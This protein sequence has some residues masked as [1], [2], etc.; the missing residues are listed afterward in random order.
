LLQN[1]KILENFWNFL[2]QPPPLNALQG[3][4]FAKVLTNLIGKRMRDVKIFD[5]YKKKIP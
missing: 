2:D 1:Q 5:F 4:F 3:S